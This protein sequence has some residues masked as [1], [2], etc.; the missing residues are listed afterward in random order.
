[1]PDTTPFR[2]HYLSRLHQNTDSGSSSWA[3]RAPTLGFATKPGL[4]TALISSVILFSAPIHADVWVLEP[5]ISLDQRFDDNYYLYP[6]VDGGLTATRAVGE[7]GLSRESRTA[8][9]K[10]LVRVDGLLTTSNENGNEGLE[11]NQIVGFNAKFRTARSRYGVGATFKQDTPSRDIAADLSDTESL[12]SDTGVN[13]SQASNVARREIV[14]NP[15]FQYDLTRRLVF[16]T[17]ATLTLVEHDLAAPQDVIY[18]QYLAI[19]PRNEDGSYDGAPKPYNE[20]TLDDV[21][22]V[23]TPSGELDNF[24]ES[25]V[26]M[27]FR[28]K[29]SPITTLSFK[30]GY[31]QFNAKVEPHPSIIVPF[32][33]KIP[34]EDVPEIRR[35]PRRDAIST[36]A[37]FKLGFERSL[38][39]TLLLGVSGGVYT[40]TTDQSNT[41]DFDGIDPS[42]FSQD[43]LDSLETESDG[44]LASVS[45][46]HNTSVTRYVGKFLVDVEP[47]SSGAQVETNE[48]TGEMFRVLSPRLNFSLRGRAYEPDRLGAKQDDRFARRFISLEP[49]IEWKYAR[50]WTVSAAYRYRRQ[51]AQVDPVAAESNAL[52]LALKYTPP[53]EIRDRAKANGL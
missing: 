51:K 11:S 19:F 7:L 46:T 42:I 14:L 17:G 35:D 52:L 37:T 39:P 15:N 24:D 32:D 23:F 13:A 49:K 27:G 9:L 12:A 22:S 18:N 5:S 33:Q 43:F 44:W 29:Y 6:S 25:E 45:L 31:S 2:Q 41:I 47:S 28:Y 48:L 4:A 53:S 38:S 3:A 10:G 36:T 30:A 20:V 16:D 40:N 21:G 1:M 26:E 34:D 8:V 50:N